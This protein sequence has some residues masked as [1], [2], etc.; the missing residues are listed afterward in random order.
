M[1]DSSHEEDNFRLIHKLSSFVLHILQ[2]IVHNKQSR[3]DNERD[4][5]PMIFLLSNLFVVIQK[6][7]FYVETYVCVIV[8]RQKP[9]LAVLH[10]EVVDSVV[11]YC[12]VDC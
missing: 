7:Q 1:R 11:L 5:V 9:F 12:K 2:V 4:N 6:M 8:L 3:D 10:D